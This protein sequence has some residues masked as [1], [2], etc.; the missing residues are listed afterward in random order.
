MDNSRAPLKRRAWRHPVGVRR[1]GQGELDARH[2][3]GNHM[4]CSD[5]MARSD[6]V[7]YRNH[8][9]YS[10]HVAYSDRISRMV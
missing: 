6:Y 10:D 8:G 4:A 3:Y 9:A 7:A 2:D 1:P 5:H